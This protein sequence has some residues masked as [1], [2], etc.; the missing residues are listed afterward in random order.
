MPVAV[1][2][3]YRC[4]YYAMKCLLS[5][6]VKN[7]LIFAFLLEFDHRTARQVDCGRRRKQ[8]NSS[9]EHCHA[10]T[11]TTAIKGRLLNTFQCY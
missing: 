2:K 10:A 8:S 5:F 11:T 4:V 6:N 9:A 7:M 1:F 3:H